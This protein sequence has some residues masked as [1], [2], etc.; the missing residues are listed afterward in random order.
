[1]YCLLMYIIIII[2]FSHM[3]KHDCMNKARQW[4]YKVGKYNIHNDTSIYAY[5]G[6]NNIIQ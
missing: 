5:K 1:M 4:T 6:Y 2:F 3:L